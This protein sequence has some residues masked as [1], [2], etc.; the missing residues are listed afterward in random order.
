MLK[1]RVEKYYTRNTW[2]N[3]WSTSKQGK[4]YFWPFGEIDIYL[5]IF[6]RFH[7]RLEHSTKEKKTT[8]EKTR[9]WERKRVAYHRVYA[10]RRKIEIREISLSG[11]KERKKPPTHSQNGINRKNS[12]HLV[13]VVPMPDHSSG[14]IKSTWPIRGSTTRMQMAT[15]AWH[16][17]HT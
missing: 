11:Q 13:H 8:N 4:T 2:K 14:T 1:K 3:H 15:I 16:R 12:V 10:I 5:Y 9:H 17:C 6:F 7:F